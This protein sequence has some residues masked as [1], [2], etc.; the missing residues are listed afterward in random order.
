MAYPYIFLT[1]YT[2][3]LA[4]LNPLFSMYFIA[5]LNIISDV[6]RGVGSEG[7]GREGVRREGDGSAS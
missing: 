7:D 6:R 1:R 5:F 2:F 4:Y 3:Y